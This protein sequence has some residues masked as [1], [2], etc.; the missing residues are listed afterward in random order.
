MKSCIAAAAFAALASASVLAQNF[1]TRPIRLI[2]PF[3]PSGA[4]DIVSRAIAPKLNEMLG[5]SVIV[6]NRAGA[7]GIIGLEVVAKSPPDGH[8]LVMGSAGPVAIV[9]GL[10][11]KLPYDVGRDFAPISMVTAMPFLLVVHPSLPVKTVKDLI[12][13]A[14]ARPGELNFGSPGN[15]STT[16]LATE[17][18]KAS[19][20][21]KLTHIPYK[22]V[23]AAA[24]DLITGQVQILS[25]DLNSMLPHVNAGKMRGIAVTSTRR[26]P[27]LKDTPTV[28][29]SGVPGFDA[30]GWMGV[31]APASVPSAVVDTLNAA[32]V[33]ALAHPETRSRLSALGGEVIGG[34]PAQFA[35]FIK[36][37]TAK[38]GT[39][40]KSA[41]IEADQP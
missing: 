38:W 19:T 40:I 3:P 23:A 32:I 12:T 15:G 18:L 25:G 27:L 5:Q 28:A 14:R 22:G 31:L 24:I 21:I 29:E 41:R 1:P 30:S 39:L 17:L 11:R 36:I 10:H 8:T 37:E 6:E 7:S 9:P 4:P 2:V 35:T 34:T 26:S 20:G 16:H 13:L 33:K